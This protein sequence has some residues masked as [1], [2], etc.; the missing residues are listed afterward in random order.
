MIRRGAVGRADLVYAFGAGEECLRHTAELL[1]FEPETQLEDDQDDNSET[2]RSSPHVVDIDF[3]VEAPVPIVTFWQHIKTENHVVH[4]SERKDHDV[5]VPADLD[6][7]TRDLH[8]P[9][10]PQP[11]ARV[12]LVRWNKLWPFARMALGRAIPARGVDVKQLVRAVARGEVIHRVPRRKRHTWADRAQL[13]IDR[14]RHLVPYWDDQIEFWKRLVR[15]R[16]NGGLDVVF[17]DQGVHGT[18]RRVGDPAMQ[19]YEPPPR[20]VPVLVLGDLGTLQRDELTLRKWHELG[21]SLG[22]ECATALAPSP[23]SRWNH[24]LSRAWRM[25]C[26]DVGQPIPSHPSSEGLRPMPMRDARADELKRVLSCTSVLVNVEPELLRALRRLIGSDV[27]V[28]AEAWAHPDIYGASTVSISVKPDP[29]VRAR[30][31]DA[32][33]SEPTY[34]QRRVYELAYAH[35]FE[36]TAR[37]LVLEEFCHMSAAGVVE[38]QCLA[39]A[40][41]FFQRCTAYLDAWTPPDAERIGEADRKPLG[42]AAWVLRAIA[43]LPDHVRE[44]EDVAECGRIVTSRLDQLSRKGELQLTEGVEVWESPS[45]AYDP[46]G[47][48]RRLIQRGQSLRILPS[49]EDDEQSSAGAPIGFIRLNSPRIELVNEPE[50]DGRPV[51]RSLVHLDTPQGHVEFPIQAASRL[52]V[53]SDRERV[54]FAPVSPEQWHRMGRDQFGLY[55]EFRLRDVVHRLRWIGPGTFEMGSPKGEAGRLRNEQL[56]RVTLTRGFWLGETTCTQALWQAVMGDNPSR[57]SGS[58]TSVPES[59]SKRPVENVS[60]ENCQSFLE[61]A[62]SLLDGGGLRLPTE[63]EW[64]YACRAGTTTPFWFGQDLTPEQ[65]NFDRTGRKQTAAVKE[66]P[67]NGWG[68]Y[69][70]HGNVWEWCQDWQGEYPDGPVEDPTEPDMGVLRVVRGGGWDN[71]AGFCRSACRIASRPG[72]RRGNLGFR[73]ARGQ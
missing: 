54:E 40:R 13:I 53:V 39:S 33:L 17:M 46:T 26:W 71:P 15:W 65:A 57:F 30:H 68:L 3:E 5:H 7:L 56:H 12:P 10:P 35:H 49:G 14:S 28:E 41:V 45:K 1:G 67:C 38:D 36:Q 22:P 6:D 8:I 66:F 21:R 55:A 47:D 44:W 51:Q 16:G 20:D 29:G 18:V 60:W 24:E 43:R 27:G 42:V 11:Y 23:R 62:N 9:E 69:Q 52:R 25:A 59:E 4:E 63:A 50:H 34:V 72:N 37:E 31:R 61:K 2:V 70:M 19:R 32:F 64:E 58:S 73:L 48:R